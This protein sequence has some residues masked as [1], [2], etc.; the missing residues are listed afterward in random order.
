MQN[1]EIRLNGKKSLKGN[2]L[3]A[4]AN[5]VVITIISS[6]FQVLLTGTTLDIQN[7]DTIQTVSSGAIFLNFLISIMSMLAMSLLNLGFNWGFLDIQEGKKMSIGYLFAPFK[8]QAQKAIAFVFRRDLLIFLWSLLLI[9]PGIIKSFAW[10]LTDF[11]YRD[12]PDLSNR[13]ILKKS[14]QM[15][16][17]N[18]WKLFRLEF[19]YVLF[20]LIPVVIW[21]INA[22]IIVTSNTSMNDQVAGAL[23]FG[24]LAGFM[25]VIGISLLLTFIIEPKKRSARAAFYKSLL[26]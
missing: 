10:A 7:I 1:R 6:A 9:V 20:Y 25:L 4:I 22:L 15:M 21:M 8:Y 2:H 13:E 17:G 26:Y 24:L 3:E 11:I 14:D 12:E 5:L 18:K 19:Y 16:Q 23:F